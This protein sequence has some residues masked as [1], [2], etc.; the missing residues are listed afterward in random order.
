[1][2]L[3][4]HPPGRGRTAVPRTQNFFKHLTCNDNTSVEYP[5]FVTNQGSSDDVILVAEDDQQPTTQK[6]IQ[7]LDLQK[8][9]TGG[10]PMVRDSPWMQL[11]SHPRGRGRS[12][13][14]R[15]QIFF[16]HFTCNDNTSVEYPRFVTNHGCSQ[17]VIL[18]AED[19]QQPTT[20]K[21]IQTLDLQKQHTRG[22]PMVRDSPWMQL[23]S[24]PRGRGRPTAPKQALRKRI[25][26]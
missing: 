24:H 14:P 11:A 22:M 20:Q 1:M 12:A 3:A 6:Y 16:K 19:D 10:M 21:Y 23:A 15:T 17:H 8:Q 25:L 9:H 4:C 18:V 26:V 7:T 13:V 5:R 2:Q